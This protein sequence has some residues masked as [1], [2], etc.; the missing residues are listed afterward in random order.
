MVT[1]RL[2]GDLA[3]QFK[4]SY[5][6]DVK[7]AGEAMH[8]INVLTRGKY[9]KYLSARQKNQ[10]K[11]LLNDAPLGNTSKLQNIEDPE[12]INNVKETELC[13]KNPNLTTV[14][15][16]PVI[17]LAEDALGIILGVVLIIVGIATGGVGGSALI[18]GGLGLLA[19]GVM[20]L[21]AK[22][23]KFED[24][25][26]I[27]NGQKSSYLF[28][29]PQNTVG[30]GGPVPIGYGRLIVGSQ[31]VATSYDIY[32][33]P[34]SDVV[35]PDPDTPGD[36]SGGAGGGAIAGRNRLIAI[37][38]GAYATVEDW[39]PQLIR[40]A[41]GFFLYL[42]DGKAV[43][44]TSVITT[45]TATDQSAMAFTVNG[46]IFKTALDRTAQDGNLAYILLDHNLGFA[47][48]QRT[49]ILRL[50]FSEI[51]TTRVTGANQRNI[52]II[53]NGTVLDDDFDIYNETS[54]FHKGIIKEY[55][56]TF[57]P[58]GR[59]TIRLNQKDSDLEPP[60]LCAYEIYV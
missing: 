38:C 40:S 23:P 60:L 49:A 14:D 52:R 54:A 39:A 17:E 58:Q 34:I 15:I 36:G 31:T 6:L 4:S 45:T 5:T 24:F 42:Q 57:T 44:S 48:G 25:R 19:A 21:L 51:A 55:P 59:L 46:E 53:C 16:V 8:A 2:H 37:N 7:S 13:L 43:S 18:V 28:N 9:Y 29:G 20:N 12:I 32:N 11:V 56:I 27:Q 22:P 35:L 47:Y 50:Y 41:N 10:Y 30:E 33:I 1:I 26:E 3:K